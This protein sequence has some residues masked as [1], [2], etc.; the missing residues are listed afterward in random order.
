MEVVC[1][2]LIGSGRL[3]PETND[4]P[5]F[6]CRLRQVWQYFRG[7]KLRRQQVVANRLPL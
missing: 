1:C 7:N 5:K 2:R 4:V 6:D 3:S